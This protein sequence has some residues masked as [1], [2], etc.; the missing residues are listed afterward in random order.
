MHPSALCS[1]H[2][3]RLCSPTDEDIGIATHRAKLLLVTAGTTLVA[4]LLWFR[5]HT[6]HLQ[7]TLFSYLPPQSFEVLHRGRPAAT[8]LQASLCAHRP[9]LGA[10]GNQSYPLALH[11]PDPDRP[12]SHGDPRPAAAS[13]WP[14]LLSTS[15]TDL[16]VGDSAATTCNGADFQAARGD[17]GQPGG[18]RQPGHRSIPG[19]FLRSLPTPGQ[20]R[21]GRRWPAPRESPCPS[22]LSVAEARG[23]GTSVRPGPERRR[24][25]P[26]KREG[27]VVSAGMQTGE[28][29]MFGPN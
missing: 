3:L 12:P 15:A 27:E 11:L 25:R 16:G 24:K 13:A 23:R 29:R 19:C 14:F 5:K 22:R 20:L 8:H 26:G 9:P 4:T 6:T 1:S 7:F 18:C 2:G 21:F 17:G 28:T 10:P